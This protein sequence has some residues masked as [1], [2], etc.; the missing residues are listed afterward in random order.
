MCALDCGAITFMNEKQQQFLN[1][2]MDKRLSFAL[3]RYGFE[4]SSVS[5]FSS[6]FLFSG[7]YSLFCVHMDIFI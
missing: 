3:K 5:L 1:S 2:L 4:S 6:F 7:L